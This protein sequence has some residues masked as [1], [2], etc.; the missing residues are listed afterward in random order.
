[1]LLSQIVWDVEPHIFKYGSF[2]IRWY[3]L[4]FAMGFLTG[5]YIIERCFKIENK[6]QEHLDKL[7]LTMMISIVIGARVGHYVFYEGGQFWEDPG[8]FLLKMITPPYSGLASHG[9]AIGVLIALF[10]FKRKNPE[11]S[12]LWLTDRM[13]IVSALGG[14]FIRFGNFMNSEIHGKPTDLPWA[15]IFKKDTTID[16]VPRHPAQLYE[17]LSCLVLFIILYFLYNKWRAKT[18]EG[19]LTGIFFIWIFGL[20]F[21]YEFIKENQEQFENSMSLN[22]GQWLSIPVVIF[23]IICLVRAMRNRKEV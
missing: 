9:A 7:L 14:A 23:G 16:M 21:F 19:S 20:R 3:G 18:P 22:M 10:I 2:E 13:V 17:S 8:Q 6:P 5:Y 11:Y 4:L 15:I 12:Y 1:M